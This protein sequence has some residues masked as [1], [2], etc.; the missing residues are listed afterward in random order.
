MAPLAG[1]FWNERMP[2]GSLHEKEPYCDKKQDHSNLDN[3]MMLLN[4]ADSLMPMISNM[5][6]RA[7]TIMAGRLMMAC[8]CGRVSMLIPC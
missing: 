6:I 4:P 5:V 7:I 3:T 8:T 2:V 1:V